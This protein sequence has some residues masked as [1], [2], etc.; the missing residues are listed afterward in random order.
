MQYSGSQPVPRG[1]GSGRSVLL[2]RLLLDLLAR[3]KS[4]EPSEASYLA[5]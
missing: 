4:G 1:P 5:T 3:R 2:L